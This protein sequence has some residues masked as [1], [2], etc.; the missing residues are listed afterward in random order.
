MAKV[1]TTGI[2]TSVSTPKVYSVTKKTKLDYFHLGFIDRS[3]RSILI[4]LPATA[5][6]LYNEK[7]S[8]IF[9]MN[10]KTNKWTKHVMVTPN[11]LLKQKLMV[12]GDLTLKDKILYLNRIEWIKILE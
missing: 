3:Q 5:I 11:R 6:G 2:V 12:C 9:F 10:K 8:K 1:T 4:Y 7:Q